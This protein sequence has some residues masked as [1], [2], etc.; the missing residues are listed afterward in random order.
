M[1]HASDS[2]ESTPA[3][4]SLAG[5]VAVAAW[6]L[7][8]PMFMLAPLWEAPTSAG[9]D[10]VVYYFPLRYLVG[11][12]LR[13]GQWPAWNPHEQC[14]MGLFA[15][16]QSAVLYPPTWLFAATEAKLAYSLNV[17]IAFALAG[18]G[19]YLY[20]RR[21]KLTVAAAVFG[22]TAF[23]YCGFMVG[24]RVHLSVIGTAAMLGFGLWAIEALRTSPR[25]AVTALPAIVFLALTAGHW[26]TFVN[27][28]LIWGVYLLVRGRPFKRCVLLTGLGVM[29]GLLLAAPQIEAS[30][31][32]LAA[33]TRRRIGI[34]TAG[35]NSFLPAN[36]VLAFFPFLMGCR[37]Q[38]FFAPR[39]WWGAWHL[40]E[41]LGY[42]GLLT[43]SL[44]AGTA[45]RLWRKRSGGKLAPMVKLWAVLGVAAGVWMLGYYIPP[46]FWLI[47]KI[48][49]LSITRAPARM[50]LAVDFALATLAAIGVHTLITR[51]AETAALRRTVCRWAVVY[52]PACMVISLGL[53]AAGVWWW[54][55]WYGPDFGQPFVGNADDV[56]ASLS[57]PGAPA[58]APLG[59]PVWVPLVVAVVSAAA[60]LAFLRRPAANA[61]LLLLVLAVDLL[62]VAR[63]VD[64]PVRPDNAI[65]PMRSASA[66]LLKADAAGEPF[67]VLHLTGDYFVQPTDALAPKASAVF[68][69]DN[70]AG[71]GPFQ[72]GPHAHLFGL[73]IYG[74][75]GQWRWLVRRNHLLSLY[76]VRYL[77]ATEAH[78]EVIESVIIDETPP[79]PDGPNLLPAQWKTHRADVADGVVTLV[80]PRM[81][82]SAIAACDD[83]PLSAGTIYRIDLEARSPEGAANWLL[84]RICRNEPSFWPNDCQ[85]YVQPEHIGRTWRRHTWTFRTPAETPPGVTFRL[86]TQSE[87]PIE[88]RNVKLVTADWERPVALTAPD[89]PGPGERVYELMTTLTT[90]AGRDISIYRNRLCLP[91]RFSVDNDDVVSCDDA[92]QLIETL[93]WDPERFDLAKTVLIVGDRP[94]QSSCEFESVPTGLPGMAMLTAGQAANGLGRLTWPAEGEHDIPYDWRAGVIGWLLAALAAVLWL[95]I[96]RRAAVRNTGDDTGDGQA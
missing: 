39:P 21:V 71:Y 95:G 14:G 49:V 46:L 58:W 78:A 47:H 50:V 85:L 19:A 59:S 31:E 87:T 79:V 74:Y 32:L 22:A 75:G 7:A 2:L 45:W 61:P 52:L 63:H 90:A 11:Q 84:A 77:L 96:L 73:R 20:L 89:A 5:T 94:N 65:D 60:L 69:V 12:S 82:D 24:H 88:V 13:A 67:R 56:W 16:P 30:F 81:W 38:N 33:T 37:T 15:D 68:G 26:P 25:R 66:E 72:T 62:I 44:A 91:R 35:E 17:F 23:Q 27:L 42:V 29:V 57:P 70:L 8:G 10:D 76:N 55:S 43:L 1:V 18:A 83:V 53:L 4:R 51:A 36:T 54:Q 64:V 80:T 28:A 93:R 40:C 6:L 48:P 86:E 9:E 41:P 3:K 92:D 34:A